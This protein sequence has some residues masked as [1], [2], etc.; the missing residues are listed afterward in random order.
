[1]ENLERRTLF[2]VGDTIATALPVSVTHAQTEVSASI[3]DEATGA[4]DVDM[5]KV[6]L[7]AGQRIFIDVDAEVLDDGSQ[8][9]DLDG[10]ARVFN[11]SGSFL[12]YGDDSVDPDTQYFS[13]DPEIGFV[14][15]ASGDYYIGISGWKNDTYNPNVAGSGTA[16]S[17]GDYRLQLRLNQ[18]PAVDP[19][20]IIA[21]V[22]APMQ[23]DLLDHV[24]DADGDPLRLTGVSV[25]PGSNNSATINDNGTPADFTDDYID[26][27]A[28]DFNNGFTDTIFA[29]VSDGIE[30]IQIQIPVSV[31]GI[32][33]EPDA[34]D[35]NKSA[36]LV[37]GTASDDIITVTRK[38]VGK[39]QLLAININGVVEG[40]FDAVS[41][42]LV[43]GAAGNDRI[44]VDSSVTI[45]VALYGSEGNDIL[46]G[47]GGNDIIVGG[48]DFSP[49]PDADVLEGGKGRDL[50]IGGPDA[51]RLDGGQDDDILIGGTAYGANF[52][53]NIIA[54]DLMAEWTRSDQSYRDRVA[55]LAN[56]GGLNTFALLNEGTAFDDFAVDRITGGSGDDLYVANRDAGVIDVITDLKKK[57]L[58][59]DVD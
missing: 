40:T 46:T 1:L 32:Q 16:G 43:V 35:P 19:F 6:S 3:G 59:I 37:G 28:A 11:A 17:T 9:S 27:L 54:N 26:Y 25:T 14:A 21:H 42:I 12:A 31:T 2:A 49:L 7:A 38:K 34:L 45:P 53:D 58:I 56:G 39:R 23:V 51:D 4:K 29:N 36:L 44:T 47:G 52:F 13:R 41:R 5:F 50:L 33:Q 15:S 8:L 48:D 22:G 10:I 20:S 30:K 55:H 57:E 24:T 18:A